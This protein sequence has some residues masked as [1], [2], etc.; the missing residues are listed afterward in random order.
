[1]SDRSYTPELI[2]DAIRGD[3][4][5]L[6]FLYESTQ[7]K[8][9]QTVRS[10]IRDE[11]AVLDIVQDSFVKA[12]RNLD[13]LDKPEYFLAWMRRIA[14]NNADDYMKKKRPVLFSELASEDGTEIEFEDVDIGH[15]PDV[16]LDQ[17]E[18]S[19]LI[20]EIISGLSEEQQLAIGLFYFEE[21]PR[22]A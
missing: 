17:Q 19:R 14:T 3:D 4:V 15:L 10:M 21:M 1:M 7:D 6:S 13:K 11:D 12:F 20:Q 9:T 2:A 5:A 16:L 22:A 8:V 18:T